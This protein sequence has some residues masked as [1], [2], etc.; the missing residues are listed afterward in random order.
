MVV[1]DVAVADVAIV[2]TAVGE[3]LLLMLSLQQP[4]C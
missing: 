4:Y 1:V 3:V 2:D